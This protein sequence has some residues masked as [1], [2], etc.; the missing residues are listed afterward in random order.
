MDIRAQHC[1]SVP[2]T[3]RVMPVANPY[4]GREQTQAKHF[5][6]KRY[7][8]GLAFKVLTF[9]DLT[10][11]D[12]F[13]GPWKTQTEDFSDSSF[14]I[15]IAVLRDAQRRLFERDGKLRRIRLFF[16][17]IHPGAFRQ[18]AAAVAP[19]HKPQD[20]FEIQTY[21]G[22]FEDA[23]SRVDAFIG[24]SLPLIFI[25]PTGWTGY[26]LAK[27]KPLFSRPKC[28]VLITFMYDFI[29]RFVHSEDPETLA[30][31]DPILGGPGWRDRLDTNLQRGVAAQ[32]LFK[33]ALRDAGRFRF[34]VSTAIDK[35][36]ADRPHFSITYA[37]K[38]L[39]GL[40]EFRE[41]E[42]R[43]L[44]EHAKNRANAKERRRDDACS[45]SSLFPG[46]DAEVQEETINQIV[47]REKE[48]AS[49]H[50][51]E[52]LSRQQCI[53]FERLLGPL[54]QRHMLRETNIKDICVTLAKSGRIE[55]TWGAGN[56]KP[57]DA[58][59]I[60]RLAWPQ[61]H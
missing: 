18:L 48:A 26:P 47:A 52:L 42:Y 28:E 16:S 22:S 53:E 12:G 34:V 27:I 36:T 5:V 37:T 11:V 45:M 24:S 44:R 21:Q 56:R 59:P 23:V 25:D 41:T 32:E 35:A 31:L 9:S 30:S 39:G 15:A 14:M 1:S 6:L 58:T 7:L 61:R 20:R 29:N 49:A 57:H 17:E 3:G 60:R 19:F 46:H 54:M 10:Y 4:A 51:L 43:A 13:C 40:R 55:R 38:S 33:E 8:E 50:L 2:L